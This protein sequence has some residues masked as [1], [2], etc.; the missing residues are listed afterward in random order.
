MCI[1][2]RVMAERSGRFPAVI[3]NVDG[4]GLNA[5]SYTHLTLPTN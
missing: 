1:R 3:L 5:V 2:D 4:D